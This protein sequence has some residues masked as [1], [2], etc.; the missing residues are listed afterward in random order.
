MRITIWLALV[1]TSAQLAF[2]DT[3]LGG[4]VTDEKRRGYFCCDGPDSLGSSRKH[5]RTR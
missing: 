5:R 3:L 4:M 2:A 1:V